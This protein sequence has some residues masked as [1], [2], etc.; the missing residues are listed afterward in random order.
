MLTILT[1][2]LLFAGSDPMPPP[3]VVTPHVSEAPPASAPLEVQPLDAAELHDL[4]ARQGV[5]V[6]VASDQLLKATNSGNSINAN[7]VGSG[8]ITVGANA[9]AGYSGVGNFVMNT[10]HNN[11]LQGAITINIVT[12]GPTP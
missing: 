3:Q 1:A 9:F 8:A 7:T 4:S 11:N 2:A 5:S 6:I 12:T 10:G